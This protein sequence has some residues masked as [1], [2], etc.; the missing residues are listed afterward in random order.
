VLLSRKS[1]V[2]Y[3]CFMYIFL[4]VSDNNRSLRSLGPVSGF[5]PKV[6]VRELNVHISKVNVYCAHAWRYYT[7]KQSL[8]HI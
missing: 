8:S 7:R 5:R 3:I 2:C 1:F 6:N 4:L